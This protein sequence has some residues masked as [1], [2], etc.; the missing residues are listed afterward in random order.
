[1]SDFSQKVLQNFIDMFFSPH[2]EKLQKQGK[3]PKPFSVSMAQ[4]VF[5]PDGKPNEIRLNEEVKVNVITT[6]GKDAWLNRETQ[7]SNISRL[8][9]DSSGDSDAGHVT[10]INTGNGSW[11]GSFD[12]LY[13]KNKA[14]QH[15][16]AA[17]EFINGAEYALNQR[18]WRLFSDCMFSA[19]ELISRSYLLLSP[20]KKYTKKG[21]H[22]VT[23]SRINMQSKLGNIPQKY[24]QIFNKFHNL[25]DSARYLNGDFQFEDKEALEYLEAAKEYHAIIN[26]KIYR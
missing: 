8:N 25:R 3:L 26:D 5:Y 11:F 22:S 10:M 18:Y 2:I 7:E 17:D 19:K 12:F 13:N 9:L 21:S 4:I 20:D 24:I 23:H 14:I 1:M 15:L 6:D 16:N